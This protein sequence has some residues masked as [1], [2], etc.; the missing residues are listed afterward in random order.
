MTSIRTPARTRAIFL[1][2]PLLGLSLGSRDWKPD[3]QAQIDE[4]LLWSLK[5][6]E[7]V[8]YAEITPGGLVLVDTGDKRKNTAQGEGTRYLIHPR[9]GAI[10]WKGEQWGAWPMTATPHPVIVESEE[11]T[12]AV[13][14][15]SNDNKPLWKRQFPDRF[16]A[17][18]VAPEQSLLFTLSMDSTTE[19]NAAAVPARLRAISIDDGELVWTAPVGPAQILD[20]TTG[21]VWRTTGDLMVSTD[22]DLFLLLDDTLYDIAVDSGKQRWRHPIAKA[23]ATTDDKGAKT[24]PSGLNDRPLWRKLGAGML[25][26]VGSHVVRLSPATG[27]VWSVELGGGSWV[28]AV[29]TDA[30]AVVLGFRSEEEGGVVL[31]DLASG[32]ERWRHTNK[33]ASDNGKVAPDGVILMP[34]RVLYAGYGRLYGVNRS[35]GR[36][37][38]AVRT[39]KGFA[40]LIQHS[41]HAVLIG[42]DRLA[43]HSTAN[44]EKLWDRGPYKDPLRKQAEAMA[45]A[46]AVMQAG[47]SAGNASLASS[48][49]QLG[50]AIGAGRSH[51]TLASRRMAQTARDLKNVYDSST[52]MQMLQT[53]VVYGQVGHAQERSAASAAFASSIVGLGT[54]AGGIMV[55]RAALQLPWLADPK[56]HAYFIVTAHRQRSFE[57]ALIVAVDLDTG[58]EQEFRLPA[59]TRACFPTFVV[60]EDAGYVV[61]VF[62]RMP[63]C[64]THQRVE[65]V[66]IPVDPKP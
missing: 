24:V 41:D 36:E 39:E 45:S 29:E 47:L 13:V 51:Y 43:A 17:G 61:E 54:T 4:R 16:L 11:D 6:D 2:L 52:R 57:R 32:N 38:F 8:F 3:E 55:G 58:A 27:I 5:L 18:L 33:R 10:V 59:G 20:E 12:H 26:S 35:N 30:E 31:L 14:A 50:S 21:N 22:R 49:G 23:S 7:R 62:Q 28:H 60:D 34:K 56:K 48:G 44:G 46:G 1:L 9:T 40:S 42:L 25:L 37:A 15:S 65:A 63:G 53:A 64:K 66:R 19:E